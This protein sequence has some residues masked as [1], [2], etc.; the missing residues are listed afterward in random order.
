MKKKYIKILFFLSFALLLSFSRAAA[1]TTETD[2]L[3]TIESVVQDEKGNPV[4]GAI[5]YGNN[6][7]VYTKTDATGK[8]KISIQDQTNLL[9]ESDGFESAVYKSG[10]I[11]IMKA[12]IL[13]AMPFMYREEDVVN[14]AFNKVKKGEVVNSVSVLNPE[15]ILKYDNIQSISDALLGRA[16]GLLGS[17]NMRGIGTP[18]YIVDGLPR[19]VSSI[20][21]AEVEQISILKDINSTILFGAEA[22]NGVILI[23]TKRGQAY[24]KQVN[25][26][27]YYGIQTPKALPQFLSSSDFAVLYNEA[28]INDGLTAA[29]DTATIRKYRT[30]NIYRYPNV[31]YFSDEYLKSIKPYSRIMTEFS[32]GDETMTYYTNLGWTRE[33]SLLDFGTGKDGNENEF[34]VRGNVDMK[35]NSWIKTS[36]DAAAVLSNDAGPIRDYWSTA[37]SRKPNLFSPLIPIALIDPDNALVKGRK[38]DV[39]G[40]YMLGGTS[41]YTT[42]PIADGYAGGVNKHI[43][44]T[45]SFNQRM[46]FDL[47]QLTKGLAFHTN[48]SFDLFTRYNQSVSNSYSVYLPTWSATVDSITGLTKYGTDT[49]SGSENVGSTFYER[50]F[51]FYG[52]LDYDR[53]FKEIHHLKGSLVGYV[54]RYKNQDN[55]LQGTKNVHIGLRL[56]YSFKDK[57]LLDY[58]SNLANS[59]KLAKGNRGAYS[60]SL[61]LAW[62]ISSEE[63]LSAVT[64]ID[65][66]KLRVSAGLLNSDVGIDDFYYWDSPWIKTGNFNWNDA[67]WY[68]STTVPKYGA[69]PDLTFEKRKDINLGFEGVFLNK[70]LSLEGNIFKH[71]YSDKITRTLTLY[72]S[73][74]TNYIP[75]T[76][77]NEY[78]YQGAEL[79]IKFNRSIGN[80]SFTIGA[81]GLYADSKVVKMDEVYTNKYQYRKGHPVDALFGLVDD[82]FFMDIAD[83]TAHEAQGFGVVKPGD[84]KYVNQD[85]NSVIDANDEIQI[86][87]SQSPFS[88]GLNVRISYKG[89]S[90]FALGTGQMG[91]DKYIN[92]NYYWVDGNDKYSNYVLNRWT[93]ATKTTAT[94]PRLSSLENLNNFRNS[95][96]WLYKNNYFSMDRIQLSYDMPELISQMLRMQKMSLY[97]DASSLFI[98]SKQ[99]DIRNLA[100]EGEPFYRAYSIGIKT[101]F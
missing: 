85:G 57:Y 88:Y 90:L 43:E 64:A 60:Q 17:S 30:G 82:G 72:P 31:D 19:D 16:T 11:K 99:N 93:E 73:F 21:L 69:N 44:R 5:V 96:F 41:S 87:R 6:G 54:T 70:M 98:I 77:N 23:T 56:S 67:V 94:F 75:Y 37:F 24:K 58:S 45:F 40:I 46:D 89:L 14:V 66:L 95:T 63:F 80:I 26:S 47:A 36:L 83:I 38:T 1:Q 22:V 33:G 78:S 76:N 53:N 97:V 20:N 10:E 4:P 61:G 28:R 92:G 52:L 55:L 71:N 50:R 86:G 74:Y 68:N 2:K 35:I 84:I 59:V 25:V 65:Y 51:G 7:I 18:L 91:G 48:A 32:G 29:Y 49:R 15:D 13:K 8:F 81:N 9:I 62:V 100:L 101:V 3:V 79:G 34:N 39:D 12:F 42:N 27:G